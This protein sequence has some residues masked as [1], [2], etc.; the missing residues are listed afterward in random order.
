ER[1]HEIGKRTARD[2]RLGDNG[3]DGC[4]H[5]LY[6][7]VEFRDKNALLF[8]DPFSL[9]YIYADTDD[10][11]RMSITVV[12]NETARLDPTHLAA[13]TS[14]T[15]LYAIFAPARPKRLAADLFHPP[16]VVEVHT[17]QAFTTSYL[18]N[19]LRKTVER[20]I[21][22]RDLHDLRVDVIGVTANESRLACQR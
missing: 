5:I 4:K 13:G 11:M 14:D 15:I 9:G 19:P 20:R 22:F 10:S 3:A 8:L 12:S 17:C 7:M 16:Y 2:Q 6:A 1:S 18:G 21:A